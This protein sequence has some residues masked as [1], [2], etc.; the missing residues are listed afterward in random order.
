MNDTQIFYL[1]CLLQR[2]SPY[3]KVF[4][5]FTKLPEDSADLRS[6][7][8]LPIFLCSLHFSGKSAQPCPSLG[9]EAVHFV[10]EPNTKLTFN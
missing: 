7:R 6:V 2:A 1:Q 8:T 10:A 4:S 5:A 9:P 3:V